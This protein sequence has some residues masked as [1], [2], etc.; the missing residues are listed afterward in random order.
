MTRIEDL[1]QRVTSLEETVSHLSTHH[2]EQFVEI[3]D[4]MNAVDRCERLF[5]L[6]INRR[7]QS[8]TRKSSYTKRRKE[9]VKRR[10]RQVKV[11]KKQ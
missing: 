1:L 8:N 10:P 6:D 7:A 4:E 2:D 9:S 5:N 11:S 3:H